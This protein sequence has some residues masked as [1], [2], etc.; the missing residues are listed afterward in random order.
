MNKQQCAKLLSAM[1]VLGLLATIAVPAIGTSPTVTV[2]GTVL[3][4]DGDFAPEGLTVK[5][6]SFAKNDVVAS[7]T[8]RD[9][10]F[11]IFSVN[12]GYYKLTFESQRKG[13]E[14]F[15]YAESEPFSVFTQKVEK[16]L[17]VEK[18]E[19]NSYVSGTITLALGAS[20]TTNAT[21]KVVD[22]ANNYCERITSWGVVLPDN[23][24]DPK[25]QEYNISFYAGKYNLIVEYPGY[26]PTFN[27]TILLSEGTGIEENVTLYKTF[28]KG[29]L[30]D[31]SGNILTEVKKTYITLIETATM[32]TFTNEIENNPYFEIGAYPGNFILIVASEGYTTYINKSVTV[33]DGILNIKDAMVKEVKKSE[34]LTSFDLT[35]INNLTAKT[36]AKLEPYFSLPYLKMANTYMVR[37][38]IDFAFGNGD[39]MLSQTELNN[40]K[41]Y[42]VKMGPFYVPNQMGFEINDTAYTNVSGFSVD[43]RD[44]GITN[45]SVPI[46]VTVDA[47]IYVNYSYTFISD[48][49]I[50]TSDSYTCSFG[51][52]YDNAITDYKYQFSLG[53]GYV[54]T[55]H[56]FD[57]GFVNLIPVKNWQKFEVDPNVREGHAIDTATMEFEKFSD[58]QPVIN[59]TAE[60]WGDYNILNNTYENYTVI[61]KANINVTFSAQNSVVAVGNITKYIWDFGDGKVETTENMTINHTYANPGENLKVTLTVIGS[62]GQTNSTNM[63]LNVDGVAPKPVINANGNNTTYVF[64]NVTTPVIFNGSYSTDSIT[65]NDTNGTI[66][67][68]AWDFGDNTTTTETLDNRIYNISHTYIG[69]EVDYTNK[70]TINVSGTLIT[71]TGCWIY[72]V[73]LNVTDIA[74]NWAN[75]T[76][77]VVVNDTE[78][79]VP[80]IKILDMEGT[81][82]TSVIE[83]TNI[84]FNASE[85]Y[86]PHGGSIVKYNWTIEKKGE[87]FKTVES[88]N[89]TYVLGGGLEPGDWNVTLTV[90]DVA[91]NSKN[92]TLVLNVR[93]NTTARPDLEITN[94]TLPEKFEV[95]T[96]STI[97]VEIRNIG[98]ENS[99]A[100]LKYLAFVLISGD[101]S[102]REVGNISSFTYPNGTALRYNETMTVEFTWTPDTAGSF[103]LNVSV[104]SDDEYYTYADNNVM[105]K[106]ITINEAAW[107]TYAMYGGGIAAVIIALLVIYFISKRRKVAE[108]EE[109]ET[110]GKKKVEKEEKKEKKK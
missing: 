72:D 82:T 56:T 80:V 103:T 107:K 109:E 89:T 100:V 73:I 68:W 6:Y 24:T 55:D 43:V 87:V 30:R 35:K 8:T 49:T 47:P 28:V 41:N 16:E 74:G 17:E 52:N 65:G 21:V 10:G 38:Q 39:F 99:S 20:F 29:Y 81:E 88:N 25:K 33:T 48:N 59:V 54:L 18:K 69:G 5:L 53:E 85:S 78:L 93:L 64:T 83:K 97:K 19:I 96:Q 70:T 101:G 40:F 63:T 91:G 62:G 27:K 32:F 42:L 67:S 106:D 36:N 57:R 105:K 15:L 90:W 50:N 98:G 14:V 77:K 66:R 44:E 108:E 75:A 94:I 60:D 84:T 23:T 1:L 7:T 4:K 51:F 102:T 92:T 104:Y 13:N 31:S 46:D 3:T 95:G 86:D 58:V 34:V 110:K 76:M 45:A 12:P 2:S 9:G 26:A 71:V 61:V 79:P 11:F 37:L 22:F